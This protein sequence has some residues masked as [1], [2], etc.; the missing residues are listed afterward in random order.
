MRRIVTLSSATSMFTATR[1][2]FSIQHQQT[3]REPELQR[4]SRL[5][6]REPTQITCARHRKEHHE[7]VTKENI[8][9]LFWSRNPDTYTSPLAYIRPRFCTA[10][11]ASCMQ[12]RA[13]LC[14]GA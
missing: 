12:A 14:R 7:Q 6:V 8:F 9:Q 5:S 10:A 2:S 3:A 11:T 13:G 1:S 4:E